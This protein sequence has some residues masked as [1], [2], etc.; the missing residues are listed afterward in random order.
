MTGTNTGVLIAV[1]IITG[2]LALL[3]AFTAAIAAW[4][5]NRRSE[6]RQDQREFLEQVRQDR[7]DARAEL[8]KCWT[9]I[10]ELEMQVRNLGGT[11]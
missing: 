11:P 10:H 2:A 7:N 3:S 9:R 4:I 1:A 6:D 8:L 5:N